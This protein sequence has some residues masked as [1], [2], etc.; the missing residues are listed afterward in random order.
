MAKPK[1]KWKVDPAPTGRYAS[2]S[3]RSWPSAHDKDG[4]T[5]AMISCINPAGVDSTGRTSIS[6]SSNLTDDCRVGFYPDA[7]LEVRIAN[8]TS[9]NTGDKTKAAFTWL[10]LKQ[11]FTNLAEAKAAAQTLYD[12]HPEWAKVKE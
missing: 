6:Y 5:A 11:K 2:F 10:V 12:A 3:S 1:L 9:H 7:Y 4:N 8:W